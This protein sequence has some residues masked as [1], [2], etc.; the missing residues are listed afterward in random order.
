MSAT[1]VVD[2]NVDRPYQVR[3]GRDLSDEVASFT[4]GRTRVAVF[5]PPSVAAHAAALIERLHGEVTVVA[6]PDAEQAKTAESLATCWDAL[7]AAGFTRSDLVIGFGGGATT[8][9]AGFV[10]ATWLRGIDFLPVPTTL[11]GMVDAA[12]GGKT[13]INLVAGKNLVGSFHQ[14]LAVSCD[15]DLLQ[16]L[17]PADLRAGMGEVVKAGFIAD[18]AIL[19]LLKTQRAA[20]LDWQSPVLA[21]LVTRAIT[22]KADVVSADP[23][24]A[25][26][27]GREVGRELLNYGHTLGHAIERVENYTWRHGEAIS[28]GMTWA[29]QVAHRLGLLDST[30]ADEHGHLLRSL[31]LPTSYDPDRYPQLRTAMGLD[32]KGRGRTLRL[33]LL[34]GVARA[35]MV[36]DPDEDVLREAFESLGQ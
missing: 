31:G 36:V 21:E 27:Q 24:E 35:I 25:T 28:V 30:T 20:A 4:Q 5:H 19:S 10:A 8:D 33:V 15:L 6:V 1:A 9:L 34:E 29:A 13:G 2:V 23:R 17:P 16:T 26:S 32:K 14:P 7:A 18:R 3:I 12:V 22:V 11:L